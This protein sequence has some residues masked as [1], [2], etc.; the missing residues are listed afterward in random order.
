MHLLNTILKWM[1][2]GGV[3]GAVITAIVSILV[4][5]PTSFFSRNSS[6]FGMEKDWSRDLLLY[7]T[8]RGA[9]L[10]LVIGLLIGVVTVILGPRR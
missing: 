5:G 4:S 8:I 2:I 6:W 7:F 1:L 9:I 3:G 10:G